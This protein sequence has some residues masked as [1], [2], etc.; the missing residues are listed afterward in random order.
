MPPAR[1]TIIARFSRVVQPKILADPVLGGIALL[2]L[3]G[4]GGGF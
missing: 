4:R 1:A 3:V 2:S